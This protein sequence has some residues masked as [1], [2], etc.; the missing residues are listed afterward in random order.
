MAPGTFVY[1]VC[2]E[3][4][5]REVEASAPFPQAGVASR[6]RRGFGA[7][8]ADRSR[9]DVFGRR[10]RG[11]D[12]SP[13]LHPAQDLS[14]SP[15]CDK[16]RRLLYHDSDQIAVSPDVDCVF[17]FYEPPVTFRCRSRYARQV[18]PVGCAP[19]AARICAVRPPS[20]GDPR[21]VRRDGLRSEVE[22]LERRPV[23]L[24]RPFGEFA[25]HWHD[26]TLLAL[27]D[28]YWEVRDQG[29]L[30]ATASRFGL[31]SH[32]VL[33]AR[34]NRVVDRFRGH[35]EARRAALSVTDYRIDT[36]Y[37]CDD[38]PP[39]AFLHFI[40]GGVGARKLEELG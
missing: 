12:R 33:P 5:A 40:N 6:H 39:P 32:A 25:A 3:R 15:R 9:P 11:A 19:A 22:P 13:G 1:C 16:W 21:E 38:H 27:E 36:G 20:A 8:W 17:S 35:P 30:A 37:S 2:G 28:P 24:F 10:T 26:Y 29:T 4:Y 34:F 7:R 31:A 14:A 23:S 18:Q